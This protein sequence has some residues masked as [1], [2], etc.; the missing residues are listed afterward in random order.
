MA[1]LTPSARLGALCVLLAALTARGQDAGASASCRATQA[2]GRAFVSVKLAGFLDRELLRLVRLGLQGKLSVEV[3]VVRRRALFFRS[4]LARVQ[5]EYELRW[6]DA[7]RVFV[8]DGDVLDEL[9]ELELDRA[10]LDV[11]LE[12]DDWVEVTA[13]LNVVTPQSLEKMAGWIAGADAPASPLSRGVL[14][15]LAR[16]LTRRVSASCPLRPVP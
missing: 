15:A 6:S 12:P 13:T 4:T 7:Q 1:P 3:A 16:D 11:E 14:G 2:P 8:L 10:A 9:D 5:H